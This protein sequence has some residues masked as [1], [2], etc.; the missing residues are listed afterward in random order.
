[1]RHKIRKGPLLLIVII[2]V[3]LAVTATR[4][5]SHVRAGSGNAVEK[6]FDGDS[7]LMA[8]GREI[9]YIG[10]DTPETGGNRPAEYGGTEAK[11][12]NETL[13]GSRE[14]RLEFDRELTDYYGRTLAYVYADEAM[15]NL[16]LVRA[17]VALAVPYPPN[18][19]HQQE[20]A[21]AME[22]ARLAGR[23]LWAD[24]ERWMIRV[25][26]AAR[27]TGESKTVVG[28]VTSTGASAAG[29]FLNFGPDYT[30]DFTAF[31][32]RNELGYFSEAGIVDPAG[33]YRDRTVEVTGSIHERN[34]P[35]ITVRHPGQIYVGR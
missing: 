26:D 2:L 28:R 15:V 32:P 3:T 13:V 7:I 27:Y 4:V 23:G 11:R 25:D 6:V 33:Y 21:D 1:M 10:I 19:K 18:L 17:G 24:P 31:I 5:I 14:V 8:D 29:V 34:G 9:R 16:E 20:F 22:E 35:S 12:L 30:T